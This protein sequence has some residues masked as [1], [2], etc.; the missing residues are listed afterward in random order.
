MTKKKGVD[1]GENVPPY[2]EG[3]FSSFVVFVLLCFQ[4]LVLRRRHAG[5]LFSS[6]IVCS[7]LSNLFLVLRRRL[8]V[9]LLSGG[10]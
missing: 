3:S 2:T 4:F 1:K 9:L 5:V 8:S 7:F 6:V 10:Y